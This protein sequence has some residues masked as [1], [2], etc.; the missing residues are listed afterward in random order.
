[1]KTEIEWKFEILGC[2]YEVKKLLQI[3]KLK[4]ILRDKSYMRTVF[5]LYE[6]V[7]QISQY[8]SM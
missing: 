5:G 3:L 8:E 7:F 1:M 4:D 2:M 6:I